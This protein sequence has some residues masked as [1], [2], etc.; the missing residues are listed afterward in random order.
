MMIGI[1]EGVVQIM[2]KKP[3]RLE[4]KRLIEMVRQMP[5]CICGAPPP[6][7]PSHIRSRGSGG[8]DTAYNVLPKCHRHHVEWHQYGPSKFFKE[9]PQFAELLIEYGWSIFEG[10]SPW[11]PKLTIR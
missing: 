9:Y 7:D 3:K 6:S 10:V 4:D 11:H 2:N 8:P 1:S 5:C